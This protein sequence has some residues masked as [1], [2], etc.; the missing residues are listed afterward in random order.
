MHGNGTHIGQLTIEKNL[1]AKRF[2]IPIDLALRYSGDKIRDSIMKMR[3]PLLHPVEAFRFKMKY[4]SG[5]NKNPKLDLNLNHHL[6]PVFK[7]SL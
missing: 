2:S 1:R 5:L 3:N 4:G 7:V 6:H